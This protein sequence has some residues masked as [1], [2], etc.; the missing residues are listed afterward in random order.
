[1]PIGQKLAP[2]A[3]ATG[4]RRG[5][6]ARTSAFGWLYGFPRQRLANWPSLPCK[7]YPRYREEHPLKRAGAELTPH[8]QWM[9]GPFYELVGR[10]RKLYGLQGAVELEGHFST[11]S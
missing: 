1:M 3:M 8:G 2:L 9:R 6:T 5:A 11:P 4:C 10:L 7:A